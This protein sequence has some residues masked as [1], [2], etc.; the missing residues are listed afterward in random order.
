MCYILYIET[1]VLKVNGKSN[2][3]S[4]YFNPNQRN[5]RIWI[6]FMLYGFKKNNITNLTLRD[7]YFR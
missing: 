4:L 1:N 2:V 5:S 7:L 6:K 3:Y